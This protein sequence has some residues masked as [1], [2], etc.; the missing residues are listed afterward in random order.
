MASYKLFKRKFLTHSSLMFS[1]RNQY[2]IWTA[3][4]LNDFSMVENIGLQFNLQQFDFLI[5]LPML[6]SKVSLAQL[7]F[8]QKTTA[9]TTRG[10]YKSPL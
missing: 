6:Q 5:V 3:N 9:A 1:S 7:R 10:E 4:Q 8:P 2:I